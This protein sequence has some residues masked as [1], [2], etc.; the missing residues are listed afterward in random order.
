MGMIEKLNELFSADFNLDT[1]YAMRQSRKNE[2]STKNLETPRRLSGLL[3]VADFPATYRFT[4]GGGFKAVPGD[5]IFLPEG[6]RYSTEFH[7]PAGKVSHPILINFRITAPSGTVPAWDRPPVRLCT[8]NGPCH[9]HFAAAVSLYESGRTALLKAKTYELIGS[10]FPLFREDP[11]CLHYIRQH[12]AGEIHI[13]DLAKKSALSESEFR[14]RFKEATGTSPLQY[15]TRLKI[16]QACKMLLDEDISPQSISEFL[17]FCSVPYF[18]KVFKA[19]T[20]LTPN[21][22]RNRS[23]L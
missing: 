13:P 23:S 15:I 2:I 11:L 19:Q 9:S 18:Y 4:D 21:Q 5:V 20:G 7:V 10:I 1:V 6:A 16:E 8:D 22:Y 14:K 12:F 17:H 3:Y